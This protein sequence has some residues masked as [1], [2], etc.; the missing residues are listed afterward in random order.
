VRL[1][2]ALS[3]LV[4]CVLL[5]SMPSGDSGDELPAKTV[6]IKQPG[7]AVGAGSDKMQVV[8]PVIMPLARQAGMV[9]P[10]PVHMAQHAM[11]DAHPRVTM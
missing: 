5:T 9:A 8:Q 7:S 1:L 6:G 11:C 2:A 3:S 4:F 10:S